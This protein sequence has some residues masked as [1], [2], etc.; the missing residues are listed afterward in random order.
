[1]FARMNRLTKQAC[2]KVKL[3]KHEKGATLTEDL[4]IMDR[5]EKYCETLY[6]VSE[7]D[8]D[9]SDEDTPLTMGG[10]KEHTP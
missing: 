3:L 2:P 5:W 10:N 8:S 6:S 7:S 4:D 9:T 1:M